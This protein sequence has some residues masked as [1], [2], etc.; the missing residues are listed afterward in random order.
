VE[1]S[2]SFRVRNQ[3]KEEKI[4]RERYRKGRRARHRSRSRS[5]K[6]ISGKKNVDIWGNRALE[7]QRTETKTKRMS[8][9]VFKRGGNHR[10]EAVSIMETSSNQSDIST[11]LREGVNQEVR[12]QPEEWEKKERN[13]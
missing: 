1:V 2:V 10:H 9:P 12:V 4:S 7:R 8:T 11:Q 6:K 3:E 5:E 13:L